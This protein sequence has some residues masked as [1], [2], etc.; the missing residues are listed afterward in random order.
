MNRLTRVSDSQVTYKQE[1]AGS[2]TR[3]LQEKLQ[4]GVSV[5]DFYANGVDGVPV[6]PTGEVDST[7]GIQAA[8]DHAVVSS[9]VANEKPC[10]VFFPHGKYKVTNTLKIRG[11]VALVGDGAP[12]SISGSRLYQYGLN[13]SL[14]SIVETSN[15]AIYMVGLMMIDVSG[16][17]NANVGLFHLDP[18]VASGNSFYFRDCWFSAPS[19]YAINMQAPTDDMQIVNCTFDVTGV[20]FINLGR[21]P[22]TL[23]P[24]DAGANVINFAIQGCTFFTDF[25]GLGF[26]DINNASAGIISGNR[27]YKVNT[28]SPIPYAIHFTNALSSKVII[29]NNTCTNIETFV[30]TQSGNLI[31]TGNI[32]DGARVPIE[33]Y[34]SSVSGLSVSGNALSGLSGI[35]GLIDCGATNVGQSV[36]TG[37]IFEG[38]GGSA[39]AVAMVDTYYNQNVIQDNRVYD[40]TTKEQSS[41]QYMS[42][43]W[44]PNTGSGVTV[45]GSFYSAGSYIRV[46]RLV[47]VTG[48]IAASTSVALGSASEIC[49]NLPFASKNLALGTSTNNDAVST[50]TCRTLTTTSSSLINIEAIPATPTVFFSIS[51]VTDY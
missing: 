30:K 42:G 17:S 27:F 39:L 14:F 19:Y 21:A 7:L 9:I 11:A 48:Y 10:S 33:V 35:Y 43:S 31:I 22:A 25:S 2:I 12:M 16:T 4:E 8:I 5:L 49:S 34:G 1:G 51:Y 28:P 50:Y 38:K 41:A 6:D 40:V 32:V 23:S 46:G 3:S 15:A 18:S 20:K 44:T 47:T 36:I 29:S 13:K 37:N 24:G 45:V 26:I